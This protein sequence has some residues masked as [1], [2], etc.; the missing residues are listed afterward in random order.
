M[1]NPSIQQYTSRN[2]QLLQ[3]QEERNRDRV[4]ALED[5][6]IASGHELVVALDAADLDKEQGV[7][8]VAT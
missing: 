3:E 2:I 7:V 6:I 1:R 8:E 4:F 5:A